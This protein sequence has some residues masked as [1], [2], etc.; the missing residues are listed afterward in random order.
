MK[1][2]GVGTVN[3]SEKVSISTGAENRAENTA[4]VKTSDAGQ[5]QVNGKKKQ[6]I[7]RL[8]IKRL[9]SLIRHQK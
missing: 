5:T 6:Q 2:G 4:S 3:S 1:V 9:N 7:K 8:L